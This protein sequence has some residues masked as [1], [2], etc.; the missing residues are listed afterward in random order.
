MKVLVAGAGRVGLAAANV[1]SRNGAVMIVENNPERADVAQGVP[2]ASVLR[3]DASNPKALKSAIERFKPDIVI[4][5]VTE[6]GINIFIGVMTK[7]FAP[8]VKTIATI[9]NID[10]KLDGP[11]P[12]IDAVIAPRE[13]TARRLS[14]CVLL[15]NSTSVACISG[16][17]FAA[18]FRI[19]KG[20]R[21][22]GKYAMNLNLS[23]GSIVAI[24]RGDEVITSVY[25][26][27]IHDEDRILV[28]GSRETIDNF[29][30]LIGVDRPARNVTVVGA[31]ELGIAT[32][33]M[34]MK[35]PG[36]HI[37]KVVDSDMA[38][39]NAAARALRG[40]VV[41]NG[42]IGD[43]IFLRSE[44]VDRADAVVAVSESEEENLL[45]CMNAVR[46]GVKKIISQYTSEEYGDLLRYSGIECAVGYHNVITNETTSNLVTSQSN[47]D[48]S[49]IFDHWGEVLLFLSVDENLPFYNM[50]LGDIYLPEGTRIV[51]VLRDGATVYPSILDRPR[52]GDRLVFYTS[53]YDPVSFSRVLG[54][55]FRGI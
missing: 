15:E 55:P 29:N 12:G 21:L 41:V 22:S 30:D 28:I 44:N 47:G 50:P 39:C 7:Y 27:Q 5:A 6:D 48:S 32:A 51:A 43:P 36:K 2:G 31:G 53:S 38:R 33:D 40:A 4:T 10:Y 52:E 11:T 19:A 20:S 16:D 9:R 23:N 3:N 26:A 35:S 14:D 13:T 42:P 17:L 8:E 54:R 24:Y 25:S 45:V 34:I 37:V 46:F 18:T 1:A 49:Y